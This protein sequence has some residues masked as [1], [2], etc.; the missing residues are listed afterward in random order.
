MDI[1]ITEGALRSHSS[2]ESFSR[3]QKLFKA[4]AVF[5][6]YR[7]GNLIGGNCEGKSEPFYRLRIRISDGGIREASCSCPYNY[8]GYC[9]H[10]IALALAHIRTPDIF[11][12][13]K[14][15]EEL[16]ESLNKKELVKLIAGLTDTD[17][18][19]YTWLELAVGAGS[20]KDGSAE[21]AARKIRIGHADY[22]GQVRRILRGWTR[23]DQ[24]RSNWITA[25]MVDPLEAI[26]DAAGLRLEGGDPRASLE[27][28]STL[29]Q[30]IGAVYEQFDDSDGELGAFLDEL[31]PP[32]VESILSAG[33]SESERERLS[34]ELEPY[35][36]DL[37]DFGIDSLE[38][39]PTA[40]QRGHSPG[41]K[42]SG[43][44]DPILVDARLNILERS[45]RVDEFLDLCRK[46]GSTRRCLLKLVELGKTGKSFD[47][48]TKELTRAEDFLS[49]AV[50]LR[51]VGREP[52][53]LR[54]AERGLSRNGN[55]YD[56]GAWLW[57]IAEAR[58]RT[59]LLLKACRVMFSE[60]PSLELYIELKRLYGTR[61]EAEKPKILNRLRKTI[62]EDVMA[63]IHLAE[64]EWDP[65]IAMADRAES[66]DYEIVEKV[67]DAVLA[68][69]PEWVSKVSRKQAEFLIA[70]TASKYYPIAARWLGKMKQ[71]YAAS[72]KPDEWSV[73]LERLKEKYPR[74]RAL[75][76]ALEKL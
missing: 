14:D 32:L 16:L 76:A 20:S 5:D 36:R 24:W 40:L 2:P 74:R 25:D 17:P 66:W 37:I 38:A 57:P 73:Y 59:D 39:V 64:K 26:L 56:L 62:E 61:W 75:Q 48:E 42:D 7:R 9:K 67:A 15:V 53:A 65:A 50:A 55:K 69:R 58:G 22:G 29:L 8:G 35:I 46:T 54:I 19:A 70:K 71:A 43:P 68:Y 63:E 30:E 60:M 33:L 11:L 41:G 12:V 31:S 1:R 4:G 23:D 3:G 10:I 34:K 18:D 13:Q 47:A 49:V 72:G 6:A 44:P 51:E 21:M 27:I 28:T 52:E 45:G